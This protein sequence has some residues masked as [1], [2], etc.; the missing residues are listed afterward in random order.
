MHQAQPCHAAHTWRIGTPLASLQFPCHLF[1][2]AHND[3]G[4]AKNRAR[5]RAQYP[6]ANFV[7]NSKSEQ[8]ENIGPEAK[9]SQGLTFCGI[10]GRVVG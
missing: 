9:V 5:G 4:G 3:G 6:L 8:I 2:A 1:C 7:E 10:G